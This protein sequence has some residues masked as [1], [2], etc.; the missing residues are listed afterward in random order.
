LQQKNQ[1][2]FWYF[3][4]FQKIKKNYLFIFAYFLVKPKCL[5]LSSLCLLTQETENDYYN[6]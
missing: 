6:I 1:K 5:A 2:Y 4:I 3:L